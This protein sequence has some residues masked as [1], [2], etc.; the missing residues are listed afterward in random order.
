MAAYEGE[1]VL[2]SI[3]DDRAEK[4]GDQLAVVEPDGPS[5]TYGKLRD[6]TQQAARL[7][8]EL[9]VAPGDR[10]ATML[11][12]TVDYLSAALGAAWAGAIEVPVN[13]DFKALY[14]E[15][16]LR[17]TAAKV[18]V[19]QDRFVE[20]LGHV[21]LPDLRH[22]VVVGEAEVDAPPGVAVHRFAETAGLDPA[23][24]VPRA[25]EDT[26]IVLFTSGTTG[27][28]KGAVH[29]NRSFM[30]TPRVWHELVGLRED[31]VGYSFLPLFHV[32]AR[33]ALFLACV[34]AGGSTILRERFSVSEFW[35]D[36]RRYG[37]TY[38]MY[39]G[40]IIQLLFKQ[41]PKPDDADNP[42]RAAG[43]AAA[44][45]DIGEAFRRRFGVELYEVYGMTEI[46]T[47]TGG[48]MG[49]N[50][51]GSMGKPFDHLQIEIHDER[52]NRLPPDRPDEIVV[53]PREPYAI[54]QGYWGRPEETLESFRNLWFHTG[55]LGKL[56]PLG[57]VVFLDRVKDSMRRRGENISS[58]EVERSVNAHP[59]V[60]ESAAYP[61]PSELTEDEVMVAVVPRPDADLDL[62]AVLRFCVETMPRF[63]VPRYLRSVAE[64]PKT[65]T[66]RVEKH[67]LRAEGVTPDTVDREA[68]GI[69]VARG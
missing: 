10:V 44:P 40:A 42:L 9:G 51:P 25:E 69:V 34:L 16:V 50:T 27:P 46:G 60:L 56:T 62:E 7:L 21:E 66:G 18:V 58:F 15:Q 24:R 43:G 49:H 6:A 8:L 17:E 67:K 23:P 32:T 4:I 53:R 3:V 20:R 28:S 33:S 31:D 5:V 61:I 29:C 57:E 54:F 39:M 19:V 35:N 41:E 26:L 63:T 68:V 1:W 64:L 52:D 36:V 14:L 30:W 12:P 13:T 59:A 37:A 65:A 2:S 22:V 48:H 47:A 45:P 11:H 55:D 38:T